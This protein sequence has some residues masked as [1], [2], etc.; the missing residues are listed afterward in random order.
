MA[1]DQRVG[2]DGP[3]GLSGQMH[4]LVLLDVRGLALPVRWSM[5]IVGARP[6]MNSTSGRSS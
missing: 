2:W 3:V 4:G 6:S 1:R 5:Q